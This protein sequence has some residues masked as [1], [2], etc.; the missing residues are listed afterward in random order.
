L[1]LEEW[2]EP[3]REP[4]AA[5]AGLLASLNKGYSVRCPQADLSFNTAS[6]VS[7]EPALGRGRTDLQVKTQAIR[8]HPRLSRP[9]YFQCG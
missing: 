6:G 9:F 2:V 1:P 8:Q 3:I 5:L 4:I 7:E